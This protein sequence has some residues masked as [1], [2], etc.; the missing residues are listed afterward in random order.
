MRRRLG[1]LV[2]LIGIVVGAAVLWRTVGTTWF[3]GP[4]VVRLPPGA[5]P[6][7][8]EGPPPEELPI[9]V[10]THKVSRVTFSDT[11]PVTGTVRGQVEMPL[12]FEVSGVIKQIAFKEGELVEQNEVVATLDDRDA[13]L[14]VEYAQKKLATAEAEAQLAVTRLGVHERLFQIGAIIRAKLDEAKAEV[15]RARAQ[16]ATAAKEVELAQAEE[17]KTILKAPISGVIGSLEVEPGEVVTVNPPTT[18]CLLADVASV[19]VELGVIERDIEKV[20]LGQRAKITVDAFPGS[21]FTGAIEQ[22]TPIIEGKS[23]TLTA[24]VKVPNEGGALLPGMFARAEITVFEKEEALIVPTTALQDLDG[25]GAFETVYTV[26]LDQ[27]ARVR[28]IR[29]GYLTTDYAEILEGLV[30]EEQV[31]VEARG[32]LKD[33]GKVLLIEVEES[34]LAREEAEGRPRLPGREEE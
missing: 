26:E 9:Q 15:A 30:E 17:A 32:K 5:P 22:M 2:L 28:P 7:I 18:I 11:L 20:K 34:G 23:R 12:K 25:D 8:P 31:V 21:E 4:A 19:N 29:L 3:G 27:T 14:R 1:L 24:K 13:K 16:V 33:G 10:R 6:A